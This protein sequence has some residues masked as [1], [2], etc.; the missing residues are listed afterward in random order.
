MNIIT[1]SNI[2][3]QGFGSVSQG[4]SIPVIAYRDPTEEDI[5]FQIGQ[6][7]VNTLTNLVFTLGSFTKSYLDITANWISLIPLFPITGLGIAFLTSSSTIVNNLGVAAN[8]IILLANIYISGSVEGFSSV[9][10]SSITAG[11]FTITNGSSSGATPQVF[12][13]IITPGAS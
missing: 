9:H 2:Y 13:V 12:Y 1:P 6:R 8:S 7:W 10:Q 3:S 5:S 11:Q 4:V